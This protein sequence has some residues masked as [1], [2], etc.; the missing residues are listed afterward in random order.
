MKKGIFLLIVIFG[1][2]GCADKD[3]VYT[4]YVSLKPVI[5]ID[6]QDVQNAFIAHNLK[7]YMQFDTDARRLPASYADVHRRTKWLK[8]IKYSRLF[9]CG[10]F[11]IKWLNQFAGTDLAVGIAH[12][13]IKGA[14][15][16]ICW[17]IDKNKEVFFF[18]PQSGKGVLPQWVDKVNYVFYF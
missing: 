17:Y 18:E 9:N 14:T 2:S 4:D 13:D 12:I 6:W 3:I 1:L 11:S 7:P 8:D 10:Y 15:H 5:R 16:Y